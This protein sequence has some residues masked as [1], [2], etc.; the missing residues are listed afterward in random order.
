SALTIDGSSLTVASFTSGTTSWTAATGTGFALHLNA[1]P[2]TASGTVAFKYNAGPTGNQ[3]NDWGFASVGLG[4][5][6]DNLV[7]VSGANVS[8]SLGSFFTTSVA[9]FDVVS[10]S[11]TGVATETAASSYDGSL[12]TLTL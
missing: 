1:G 9:T 3:I 8:V 11:V 5:L 4:T 7:E 12:L 2:L 10:Q 6:A